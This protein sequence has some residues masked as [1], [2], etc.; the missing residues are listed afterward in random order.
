MNQSR[1]TK[2]THYING[3]E[4]IPGDHI[5]AR[6]ILSRSGIY[7]KLGNFGPYFSEKNNIIHKEIKIWDE[8]GFSFTM[9]E[10]IAFSLGGNEGTTKAVWYQRA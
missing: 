2:N 8:G 6:A 7:Q 4:H 3:N 5:H 1:T 9:V 10:Y